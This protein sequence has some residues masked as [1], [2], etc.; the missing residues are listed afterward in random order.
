[1]YDT[2]HYRM[3]CLFEK[4]YWK[5]N[6]QFPMMIARKAGLYWGLWVS[7][8]AHSTFRQVRLY[9]TLSMLSVTFQFHF[10]IS[11]SLFDQTAK[12]E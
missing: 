2:S 8:R 5:K 12:H 1:M 11:C 9:S 6:S 3:N 10:N 7:G 4:Y